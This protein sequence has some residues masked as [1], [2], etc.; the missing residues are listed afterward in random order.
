MSAL[1]E[2]YLEAE[3]ARWPW[4]G[5]GLTGVRST[6]CPECA[7]PLALTLRGSGEDGWWRASLI[8]ASAGAGAGACMSL[9]L[10]IILVSGGVY[11]LWLLAGFVM[12][13]GVS[14]AAAA[15]LLRV[16]RRWGRLRPARRMGLTVLSVVAAAGG[17][18]MVFALSWL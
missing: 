18:V 11:P 6:V 7:G 10:L 16:R 15:A 8:A 13:L 3:A 12:A 5:H 2:A 1:L 4:C 9:Y 14:A 17:P